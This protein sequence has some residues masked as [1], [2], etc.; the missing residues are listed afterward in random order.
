MSQDVAAPRVPDIVLERYRLNELPPAEHERLRDRLR[1]DE[2][3]R[4][5]ARVALTRSDV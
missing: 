1:H 2:A 5:Q 3:L 4:L